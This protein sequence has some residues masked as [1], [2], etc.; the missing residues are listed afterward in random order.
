MV[1]KPER[2]RVGD[3]PRDATEDEWEL[4]VREDDDDG[5]RYVGSVTAPNAEIAHEQATK[6]FAWY[7]DEIWVCR[8]ADV[9][10][11]STHDLDD[12]ASPAS[13]ETGD[14]QRTVE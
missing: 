2:S 4:F 7:A 6:L 9:H 10:R 3:H 14:E 5:L 8:A 13:I 1:E 12:D 11:F